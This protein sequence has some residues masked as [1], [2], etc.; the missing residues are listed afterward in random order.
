MHPSHQLGSMKHL[1]R[2][3]KLSFFTAFYKVKYFT[4]LAEVLID[5]LTDGP[6]ETLMLHFAKLPYLY[7]RLFVRFKL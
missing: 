4:N 5:S 6:K 1:L 3:S 2:L 7:R